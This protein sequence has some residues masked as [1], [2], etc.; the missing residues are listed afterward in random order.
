MPDL[1]SSVRGRG[2][3]VN[4]GTNKLS[5]QI[6]WV[7]NFRAVRQQSGSKF[8]GSGGFGSMKG[9]G[10]TGTQ[11]LYYWDMMFQFGIMDQPSMIRQG[12]VGSDRIYGTVLSTLTA[13][14]SDIIR[15]LYPTH[16]KTGVANSALLNYTTAF[17]AP[18]Y[19]TGDADLDDW[20]HLATVGI[21]A[22]FPYNAW[23]GFEQLEL[24]QSPAVPQLYFEWVPI[25]AGGGFDANAAF[26]STITAVGE[27]FSTI[28]D[29]ANSGIIR[30]EDG[31]H[32]WLVSFNNGN[33]LHF[34]RMRNGAH[35]E[36]TTAQFQA[37][38]ATKG[39]T[40]PSGVYADYTLNGS[41]GFNVSCEGTPYVWIIACAAAGGSG[42]A[43]MGIRYKINAL[44]ALEIDGGLTGLA[45]L[46]GRGF[47]TTKAAKVSGSSVLIFGTSTHGYDVV[48]LPLT[49]DLDLGTNTTN[50]NALFTDKTPSANF[51]DFLGPN[52]VEQFTA[53][54]ALQS[55]GAYDILIYI[56]QAEY[57]YVAANP[58]HSTAYGSVSG[59]GVYSISSGGVSL[60]ADFVFDDIK[61]HH[62]GSASTSY[63]DDYGCGPTSFL[64][65]N[66]CYVAFSRGYSSQTD[67]TPD[68]SFSRV[69]LYTWNGTTAAASGIL[70]DSLF[71]T[72][73]DL[74]F[75]EANRYTIIQPP[76][77]LHYI[78][79]NGD[80]L[81]ISD[82]G[83]ASGYRRVFGVF[84]TQHGG[85]DVTPAYIIYRI[86]TSE[87]FGFS[88]S[89]LFGYTV[90]ADR[91]NPS[92]YAALCSGALTTASTFPSAT[93]TR[94]IS[95]RS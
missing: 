27:G 79:G 67:N 69:R 71:D 75:T 23:V 44:G 40:P 29:T 73:A 6:G 63:Y 7:N 76:R 11:Y 94:A 55:S 39:L 84:A 50:W 51:F 65:N 61:K 89:A 88:T 18:G 22:R 35:I 58:G 26:K 86:L 54:F 87:V 42:Y 32:Y 13:G 56:G 24:G 52:R 12:W 77:I 80:L 33:Y 38:L 10:S 17:V 1:N 60:L 74:G 36:L 70:E 85:L 91:I 62:D 20:S 53:G 93:A 90:T 9:G 66:I 14:Q 41:T 30:G 34:I 64:L 78:D 8:G 3:P 19:G 68:G 72:V 21:A 49:G 47:F 92:E 59:P 4:F 43:Y 45:A 5:S 31:Q 28:S 37:D 48:S 2:V 46:G 16:N 95:S 15:A 57:D 81:Y 82:H 83:A 25:P